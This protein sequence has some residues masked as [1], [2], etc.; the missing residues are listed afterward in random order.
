VHPIRL[1]CQRRLYIS[2]QFQRVSPEK[3]PDLPRLGNEHSSLPIQQQQ[4]YPAFS[5]PHSNAVAPDTRTR[6]TPVTLTLLQSARTLREEHRYTTAIVTILARVPL[7]RLLETSF[8]SPLPFRCRLKVAVQAASLPPSEV[9]RRQRHRFVPLLRAA[10]IHAA[11]RRRQPSQV[12]H[13]ILHESPPGF[14]SKIS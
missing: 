1:H 12:H 9:S 6:R 13:A 7:P 14:D 3:L 4:H 2:A 5:Y 8:T 10:R 11:H